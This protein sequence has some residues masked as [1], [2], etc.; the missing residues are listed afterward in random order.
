MRE[1]IENHMKNKTIMSV[2]GIV[3]G[4]ILM[5]WRGQF[6]EQMI[7]VAG[8]VLLVAA[9]AYLILYFRDNRQEQAQLIY[10]LASA[11]AGL[12]LILLCRALLHA[13]PVIVGVLMILSAAEMLLTSFN[14]KEKPLYSKALAVLVIVLGILVV[15][16]PGRIANTLVFCVGAVLVVNGISG[17]MMNRHL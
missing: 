8:Y 16:H 2:A 9:A 6:V 10:A 11:G 12:L 15:I 5:I 17:L 7:R 14:D 3:I 1:T 4:L 13:F